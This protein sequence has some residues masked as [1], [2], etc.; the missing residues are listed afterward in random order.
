MELWYQMLEEYEELFYISMS[1]ELSGSCMT[2]QGLA[3]RLKEQE[4]GD[5]FLMVASG[6]S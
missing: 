6:T 1:N 2:A 5:V 4:T 3:G